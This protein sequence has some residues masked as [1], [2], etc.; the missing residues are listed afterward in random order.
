M[1]NRQEIVREGRKQGSAHSKEAD[2]ARGI[3]NKGIRPS[4]SF[5]MELSEFSTWLGTD[6]KFCLT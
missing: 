2:E 6:Y 4:S 5:L 3:E 1:Q